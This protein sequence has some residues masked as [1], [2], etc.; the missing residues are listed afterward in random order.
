MEG[1]TWRRRRIFTKG[2]TAWA[3]VLH[4]L[5]ALMWGLPALTWILLGLSLVGLILA[6]ISAAFLLLQLGFT[7][8]SYTRHTGQLSPLFSME[9][10]L[11][12]YE[13]LFALLEK[14]EFHSALLAGH[15]ARVAAGAANGLKQLRNHRRCRPDSA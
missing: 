7:L 11:A 14:T 9:R 2:S 8:F 3:A 15:R 12:E 5:R 10:D 6:L 1:R 13:A 4:G